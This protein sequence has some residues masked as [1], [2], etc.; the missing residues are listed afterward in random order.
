MNCW[1]NLLKTTLKLNKYIITIVLV[2]ALNRFLLHCG[3]AQNNTYQKKTAVL[4]SLNS[5]G[6]KEFK[7]VSGIKGIMDTGAVSLMNTKTAMGNEIFSS[8]ATIGAGSRVDIRF[9]SAYLE[10]KEGILFVKNI[11]STI[12]NNN[13]YNAQI[14]RLG[15]FFHDRG[16]KTALL[17]I[18]E[19]INEKLYLPGALIATD[20]K[21]KIDFGYVYDN[22]ENNNL[23]DKSAMNS[24]YKKFEQVY[25]ISNL[26]IIDIPKAGELWENSHEVFNEELEL[27]IYRIKELIN[28]DSL[29]IITS[30]HYGT[31]NA[32]RGERLAP[33]VVWSKDIGRGI[34]IS[35]T[36][37][38]KGIIANIDIAPTI[39]NFF[40]GDTREMTGRFVRIINDNNNINN[41]DRLN[42]SSA[43]NFNNRKYYKDV[44]KFSNV[45]A[46]GNFVYDFCKSDI[47]KKIMFVF[48]N[49]CL[50]VLSMPLSLF[51][52]P[53]LIY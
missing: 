1:R 21:G 3:Y 32:H 38:R 49:L 18:G 48:Q 16:L 44:Y 14:G 4:V 17:G 33:V 25:P 45:F 12:N 35:G 46:V 50:F 27:F 15:K 28:D 40:E 11:E 39:I 31:S 5:M 19:Y 36:T 52:M 34:L 53:F 23:Y 42:K 2:L 10:K 37:R 8:Y 30:P 24:L 9:S 13:L 20:E 22:K 26:I 29:L 43:F 51:L 47:I 6:F 7:E 41:I